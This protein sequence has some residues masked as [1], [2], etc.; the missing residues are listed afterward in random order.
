[1][2]IYP[3]AVV[4]LT[5]TAKDAAGELVDPA[6]L[7][8][9]I[10]DPAEALKASVPLLVNDAV[11]Q[12]EAV[13]QHRRDVKRRVV[14]AL[15]ADR[16]W[17]FRDVAPSAFD[18]WQGHGDGQPVEETPCSRHAAVVVVI[19][20]RTRFLPASAVRTMSTSK[21]TR[22]PMRMWG[23][24]LDFVCVRSQRRLGLAPGSNS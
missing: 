22:C 5:C 16:W 10:V 4:R 17:T 13:D 14:P 12:G 7:T 8:C 11:A 15:A 6:A 3:G 18:D 19:R 23:I 2:A 20:W 24:A 21:N 9:D 1:M